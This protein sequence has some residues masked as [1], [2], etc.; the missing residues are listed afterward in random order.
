[1]SQTPIPADRQVEVH[2]LSLISPPEK[3]VP[4][5]SRIRHLRASESVKQ[6]ILTVAHSESHNFTGNVTSAGA[7]IC[8]NSDAP[9]GI[10]F[11]KYRIDSLHLPGIP[12]N[13]QSIIGILKSRIRSQCPCVRF[14]I[15]TRITRQSD[16]A[17][18]KI[19]DNN[20]IDRIIPALI[21]VIN[22]VEDRSHVIWFSV[23]IDRRI[24]YKYAVRSLDL[25]LVA[26]DIGILR[27]RIPGQYH[28]TVF[29]F[30]D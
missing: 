9:H 7:V 10:I 4:P 2:P 23:I 14:M 20:F 11:D 18:F 29:D 6:L 25:N 27:R 16:I 28:N 17:R 1:M 22:L 8:F 26:C 24:M 5:M 19:F 21:I 12:V 15:F 13:E 3:S 30:N